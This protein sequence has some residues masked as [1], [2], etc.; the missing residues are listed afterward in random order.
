MDASNYPDSDGN[1]Y[2]TS[3][4]TQTDLNNQLCEPNWGKTARI[5]KNIGVA[6]YIGTDHDI[7]FNNLG[8][9]S[10]TIEWTI[11]PVNNV[12]YTLLDMPVSD[13]IVGISRNGVFFFA[14]TSHLG[15]DAFYPK[16]YGTK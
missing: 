10:T 14:G 6:E 15:Y 16:A 4:T 11:N 1:V 2:A 3:L 8:S 13:E 5:D 9:S 7:L 12:G